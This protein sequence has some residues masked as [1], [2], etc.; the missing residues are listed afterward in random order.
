M[1]VTGLICGHAQLTQ[2]TKLDLQLS[3]SALECTPQRL[4]TSNFDAVHD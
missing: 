3:F 1:L 4:E 2:R